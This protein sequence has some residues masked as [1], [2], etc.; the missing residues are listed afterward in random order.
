MPGLASDQAT[1][2]EILE[3]KGEPLCEQE[4]WALLLEGGNAL[5]SVLSK[6]MNFIYLYFYQK[7]PSTAY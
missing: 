4:L 2:E 1:L 3:V 7:M 5:K 6:S